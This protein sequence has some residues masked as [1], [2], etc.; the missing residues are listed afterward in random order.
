MNP[1]MH[2][3]TGSESRS[4]STKAW[5]WT[6]T[7]SWLDSTNSCT[8][9]LSRWDIESEWRPAA[10]GR[11]ARA[12]A[13][14]RDGDQPSGRDGDRA[15]AV[16]EHR[17]AV[18]AGEDA[19]DVQQRGILDHEHVRMHDGLAGA[20]RAVADAAE[21]HHRRA[22]ALR[23]EARERLRVLAVEETRPPTAAPPP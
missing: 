20:D 3:I 8:Q 13:R 1:S 2:T 17:A 19:V 16:D 4:A 18:E 23:A 15:R 22:R 21:R 6:W 12:P 10:A 9:P 11:G 7:A 5:M 14:W